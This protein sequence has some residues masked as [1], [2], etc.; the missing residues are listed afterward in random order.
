MNVVQLATLGR[1]P[2]FL[3]ALLLIVV[4]AVVL[5]VTEWNMATAQTPLLTAVEATSDPG[6]D[7]NAAVWDSAPPVELT[8]T[9]QSFFYPAGGVVPTITAQAAHFNDTLYVR[10]VWQDDSVDDLTFATEEFS[11]AVA[12]EFPAQSATSVPA[13]CMGQADAGVNIWYWRADAERGVSLDPALERP[14]ISVDTYHFEGEELFESPAA[15]VGNVQAVAGAAQ[16]L[17]ARSFGTLGPSGDQT[18]VGAGVHGNNEWT[19]VLARPFVS[20]DSDQATFAAGTMTD[21][22]IAV[23]D[24]SNDDRNGQKS[25]SQFLR[26]E[27]A[28]P[29]ET[30]GADEEADTTPPD[31]PDGILTAD[32]D[33]GG[34]DVGAAVAIA[35]AVPLVLFLLV[36]MFNRFQ[37]EKS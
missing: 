23:W 18:V 26:L 10:A 13:V 36:M 5:R 21:L 4:L 15:Y 9:A 24:G 2:R 30:V 1:S 14:G 25:V 11:D 22:A 20:A 7:P 33:D 34:L 12:L 27:V 6:T 32:D 31:S 37:S 16:N 3:T 28:G 17:V 35:I 29:S 8:L 19:V